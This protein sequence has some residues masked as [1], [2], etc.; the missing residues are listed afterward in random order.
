MCD[1]D[2]LCAGCGGQCLAI[3]LRSSS[4]PPHAGSDIRDA[5]ERT[6]IEAIIATGIRGRSYAP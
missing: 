5:G 2:G 6:R 1:E 4:G 3:A